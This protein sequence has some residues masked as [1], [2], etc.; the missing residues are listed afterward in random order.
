MTAVDVIP[1]REERL[2]ALSDAGRDVA[3]RMILEDPDARVPAPASIDDAKRDE[4]HVRI[5]RHDDEEVVI[6]VRTAVPGYL[7][8]ADPWDPGWTARIDGEPVPVRIA[9]HYLRAVFVEPGEHEVRFRFDGP[10][11]VWPERVSLLVLVVILGLIGFS[12]SGRQR[13]RFSS[14]GDKNS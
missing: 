8:L 6:E 1:D 12:R 2:R 14:D 3:R 10:L 13:A 5:E 11:V 4:V 7:R 9:D